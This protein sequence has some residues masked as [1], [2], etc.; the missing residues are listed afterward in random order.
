MVMSSQA[1]MISRLS[2][3]AVRC[4][5]RSLSCF[6]RLDFEPSPS[7]TK[8]RTASGRE[9]LGSGWPAIQASSLASS[10]GGKRVLTGVALMRGRPIRD[11]FARRVDFMDILALD[12]RGPSG[13]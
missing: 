9:G 4:D 5:W 3:S 7:S 1:V 11:F 6:Q 2:L 8:R 13:C 12:S 10:A